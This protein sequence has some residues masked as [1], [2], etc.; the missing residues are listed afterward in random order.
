M[1]K[2][3]KSKQIYELNFP[4]G[5][6]IGGKYEIISLLGSG[7]EG[8]VY[9][10]AELNTGVIRAAK[11]FFPQRNQGNKVATR[12]AKMLNKLS[13]CPIVTHYHTLDY[14]YVG[15]QRITCLISEYVDGTLLSELIKKQPRKKI[16]IFRGLHLL[17]AL[18]SGLEAMHQLKIYHG[19]LHAE[20]IIVK[21]SGLG[22]ELML[23]DMYHHGGNAR[24]INME[25]DICD[26]IRILYDAIGGRKYYSG[27]PLE[28]KQICLGLKRGL[29]NKKFRSATQLRMYLE[30]IEWKSTYKD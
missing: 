30:N 14:A 29:I 22:F 26:S 12:Y 24:R 4:A 1:S 20:N 27:H 5:K 19:D 10:V 16:G 2:I 3:K 9:K 21:R 17:H 28:I 8:E 13:H 25:E 6:M 7:W 15:E 23:L 11:F 18:I